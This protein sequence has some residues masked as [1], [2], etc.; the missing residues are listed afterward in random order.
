MNKG[1]D[2]TPTPTRRWTFEK[3]Y[4]IEA[5]P[6][7]MPWAEYSRRVLAE[8]RALIAFEA[9]EQ[10]RILQRF[11][12]RHPSLVPGAFSTAGAGESGHVPFPGA[13]ITQPP[14]QG[15]QRR[16]PDFMWIAVDSGTISPVLVEI[17]KPTKRWFRGDGVPTQDLTQAQN[18]LNEWKAWFVEPVHRTLFRDFFIIPNEIWRKCDFRPQYMLVYGSRSEFDGR[19]DLNKKRRGLERPDEHY[20]TFDRLTPNA[21]GSDLMCVKIT[22]ARV[23]EA[24]TWPPTATLGPHGATDRSM[25]VNVE[26]AIEASEWLTAARRQFLLR[27]WPYWRNWEATH[28]DDNRG[29]VD[30]ADAE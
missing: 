10:E 13:V 18:Q 8:W 16:V 23:F 30:T 28:R 29:I 2:D 21:N 14:L 1:G 22:K 4:T 5:G 27:R 26:G 20:M 17:E 12:E 6:P 19:A 9:A 11:L 24:I 3:T 15:L 7:P 25:F